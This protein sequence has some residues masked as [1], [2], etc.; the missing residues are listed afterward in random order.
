PVVM[1]GMIGRKVGWQKAP[2]LPGPPPFSAICEQVT[3]GGDNIWVIP[4]LCVSREGNHNV[5]RGGET[6][7]LGARGLF[8]S[9][10]YVHAP[11]TFQ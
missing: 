11:P 3:A 6:Q 7:P 1:A 8:P 4:G 5:M 10:V 2:Y 9:S